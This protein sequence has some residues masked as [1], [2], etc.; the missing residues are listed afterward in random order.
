[1]TETLNIII[2]AGFS[3]PAGLPL[4]NDIKAKFDR[5]LKEK[6]MR[7]PSSEWFWT[8][9]KEPAM[10]HNGRLNTDG[11]EYE[12]VMEELIK[13]YKSVNG[14]FK[15][16]ED[17]YQYVKD[18][19]YINGW[20]ENILAL[21]K[22]RFYSETK[23]KEDSEYCGYAFKMPERSRPQEIINYLISDLLNCKKTDEELITIYKPFLDYL[24]KY[25]SVYI[26]TLNHDW[27]FEK[28]FR[29]AGIVYKDG[30]S[31]QGTEIYF[32]NK[33]LPSFKNDFSTKGIN[34]IK[35]HGSIDMYVFE[36]GE[37][38]GATLTRNGDYTYFKPGGY[39][40]KHHPIRIDAQTMEP[41]QTMNFDV[42]PKF[43]TGKNKK[44]FIQQDYMYSKMYNLYQERI[45]LK[46]DLL[47][48]GYSYGDEHI[49][50][51]LLKFTDSDGRSIINLNPGKTFPY[52]LKMVKQIQH[53]TEL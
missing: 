27:I 51:E 3:F 46:D 22:K 4:G 45:A 40:E 15:D 31:I 6:L 14:G 9:G 11:L 42:V 49:N 24:L 12:F 41:I 30:F 47:I 37:Q 20:Y 13:K 26:F 16:Y 18:N 44:E 1:M 50:D 5:S 23:C 52:Q 7:M 17:F 21:A 36:H 53:F 35:L 25:Q 32:E 34:L 48:I 10:V 39:Q 2:G 29:K 8:E 19:T 28:L 38:E 33:P 43:I